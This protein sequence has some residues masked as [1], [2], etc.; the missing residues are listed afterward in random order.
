MKAVVLITIGVAVVALVILLLV[1]PAGQPQGVH[2]GKLQG[3]Q[4]TVGAWG[5]GY[6]LVA[7]EDSWVALISIKQLQTRSWAVGG[8]Y[9]LVAQNK[10]WPRGPRYWLVQQQQVAQDPPQAAKPLIAPKTD[11]EE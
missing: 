6:A 8:T 10:S 3:V 2:A 11:A 1:W 7:F 4:I 5:G 9:T